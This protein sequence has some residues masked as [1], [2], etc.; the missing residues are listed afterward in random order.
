MKE[1]ILEFYVNK[2]NFITDLNNLDI[3][4]IPPIL[5]RRMTFLDKIALSN[6]NSVYSNSI[7]NIVFSSQFGQVE[8]LLKLISQYTEEKEVSPNTFSGS[9]HNYS[10]GFF[11]L[12]KQKTIP[13]TAISA[14]EHSISTGILTSVISKYNNVLFCYSDFNDEKAKSFAINLS[15]KQ[16]NNSK[17]YTIIFCTNDTTEDNFEN[18]TK[19]FNGEM[20][21]IKTPMFTIKE[22]GND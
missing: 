5:R 22:V 15:K 9:V 11:L 14:G 21:S 19:M 10:T 20:N 17:R 2:Y 4:F 8:R 16:T 18:F 12:N 1:N 13:Y 6:M 3:T 7:Q